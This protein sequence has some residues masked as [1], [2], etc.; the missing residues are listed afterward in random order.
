M[1]DSRG[2]E[3]FYSVSLESEQNTRL[4]GFV[5]SYDKL[6]YTLDASSSNLAAT[7]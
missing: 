3:K 1:I 6:I 5:L 7:P 2:L 4:Q